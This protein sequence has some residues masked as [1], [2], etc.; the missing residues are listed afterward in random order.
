MGFNSGFK[1]LSHS[2]LVTV[3]YAG[4]F[5]IC[6]PDGHKHRI[7]YARC[8]IDTIDSRA[9][10]M[11]RIDINIYEKELCTNLVIYENYTEM[12][13][14]R[15]IKFSPINL[16]HIPQVISHCSSVLSLSLFC[17]HFPSRHF[18]YC[19]LCFPKKFYLQFIINTL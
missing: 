6:T 16:D 10:N 17:H 14:Q 15:N 18:L 9:R 12:H 4:S 3:W 2:V 11:Q 13:G 1:G 8:R 19:H 7:T 5:Q